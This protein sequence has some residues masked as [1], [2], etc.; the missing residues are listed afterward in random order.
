[1][2]RTYSNHRTIGV[3]FLADGTA[4]IRVWAP[5]AQIVEIEIQGKKLLPLQKEE[6]GYWFLQSKEIKPGDTYFFVLDRENKFP[7]PASLSQPEGVHG[8]SEAVDLNQGTLNDQTWKGVLPEDLI[9]YELHVGTFTPDGTFSGVINKLD[10]LKEL[11]ITALEIMPVAQFPGTRNWGYDGVYLFAVQDS[12]GGITGLKT[13][14]DACHQKGIAVLLDVVY[15]HLGPEGN[16]LGAYGP[17]FTEKYHTPW[18]KAINFDDEWCDGPRHFFIENA[19]MWFR[20]FH[21]DGLRLDALHAIWDFSARHILQELRENT[22]LLNE[23]TGKTHLLIGECALNDV[24]YI[25]P[26]EKGGYALDVVWCDEFH[27]ALHAGLTGEQNGYYM[28]FGRIQQIAKSL[29]D[30]FIYDGIYS[31]FRKRVFGSKTA[32][33][34]GHKFVVFA[35]NHDQIG[36]RMMGERLTNLVDFEALKLVVGTMLVSPYIP[37]L[38]MGEEY[39]E[40]SPFLY[41][42]SHSDSELVEMV[43][44]GRKEEFK[45][46]HATGEPFDPQSEET[47][48]KSVLK[49]NFEQDDQKTALLDYYKALIRLRKEYPVFRNVDRKNCLV[50]FFEENM[51]ILLTHKVK[52]KHLIAVMNF[53]KE[54]ADV[55][56][57]QYIENTMEIVLYSAEKKWGGQ[58][59]S[60]S[61]TDDE[62]RVI[63]IKGYS[64]LILIDFQDQ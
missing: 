3:N 11:G 53:N 15:N 57:S 23:R 7:D 56:L 13:L 59:E 29:K 21:I 54:A 40:E 26:I 9:I 60:L 62:M 5:F 6:Y 36:N 55:D 39:G 49:W 28:D 41:F 18:G 14:V 45:A 38:F 22:Y 2:N 52:E 35:Q 42:I 43:R 32:G 48:Q 4:F 50:D 63:K 1:M 58:G 10:Y 64:I 8:P 44:K 24:R 37:L 30:A 31:P 25:N 12:Y 16:Y 17:Y 51:I 61:G 20:D 19:L 27:H 34:P 46:F 47:F 33:Q